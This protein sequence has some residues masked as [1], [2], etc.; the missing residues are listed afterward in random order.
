MKSNLLKVLS[1]VKDRLAQALLGLIFL[2][3]G[4]NSVF[5]MFS[6]PTPAPESHDFLLALASTHYFF[7]V[8]N[9][10][11]ILCGLA[12]VTG[13]YIKLSLVVLAPIVINIILFHSFLD[14]S[15]E[16][17][18]I[19][20]VVAVLYLHALWKNRKELKFLMERK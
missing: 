6:T 8:L 19:P 11:Q 9:S 5:G 2:A 7:P 3:Y 10:L 12:L 17:F 15:I 18:I 4:L 20:S 16:S 14:N 1:V 13:R